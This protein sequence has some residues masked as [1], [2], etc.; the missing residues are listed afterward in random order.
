MSEWLP[1]LSLSLLICRSGNVDTSPVGCVS[2]CGLCMWPILAQGS[3]FLPA[4]REA[5][6]KAGSG[7]PGVSEG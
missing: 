6:G 3:L 7:Q 4:R 5:G 1:H 2:T